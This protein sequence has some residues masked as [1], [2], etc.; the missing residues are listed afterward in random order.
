MLTGIII[1]LGS[2]FIALQIAGSNQTNL[3]QAII[4]YNLHPKQD[5]STRIHT[6]KQPDSLYVQATSEE[7]CQS[8]PNG[9]INIDVVGGVGNTINNST[10]QITG[11]IDYTYSWNGP[12]NYSSNQNNISGLEPGT[13][14][15]T[16]ED[17]NGCTVSNSYTVEDNILSLEIIIE[18]TDNVTCNGGN[19]GSI[20]VNG[21]GGQEPYEYRV[22]N[23]AWQS[24]GAFSE[25][26]TGTYNIVT[27]DANDCTETI[28]I[29]IDEPNNTNHKVLSNL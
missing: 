2:P 1:Q 19:D 5:E 20:V 12:D 9:Y 23:G 18:S 14:N 21:T 8:D 11:F 17:N 16:V 13:Y 3:A 25:L 15:L 26:S 4:S 22:N 7:V 24:T 6:I 27:K 29:N 10:G 28:E